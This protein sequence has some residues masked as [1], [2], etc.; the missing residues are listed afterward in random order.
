MHP[1]IDGLVM[2]VD[3]L[4]RSRPD[5]RVIVGIVGEPGSGKTTLAEALVLA[6]LNC[7]LDWAAPANRVRDRLRPWI[8][9]HVAHVPM[10]GFHFADIELQRL[11][12]TG[13]KGAPDT[14]DAA[15]YAALLHR[16]RRA[17]DDVWAPSFDRDIEQPVAGSIPILRST[18]VVVTEGNYLLMDEPRWTAARALLDETWYCDVDHEVRVQR[19]VARHMR[20]GKSLEQARGWA[21]GSDQRNADVIA[22]TKS[23]ADLIITEDVAPIQTSTGS[24]ACSVGLESGHA[25]RH[26]DT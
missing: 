25:Y 24:T 17:D 13:R 6:L 12:R 10:D 1:D 15:S 23:R 19:L 22:A 5:R 7:P 2:R 21:T 18:R 14:F 9:S 8:G 16:I 11:G 26:A 20:F 4:V 3:A